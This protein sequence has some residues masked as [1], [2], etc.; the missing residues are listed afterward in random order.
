MLASVCVFLEAY[1]GCVSYVFHNDLFL[2]HFLSVDAARIII[3]PRQCFE[4]IFRVSLL[5]NV[6]LS[7]RLFLFQFLL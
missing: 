5:C 7:H 4:I 3:I 2:F 1:V 6:V